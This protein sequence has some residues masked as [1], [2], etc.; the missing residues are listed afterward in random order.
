VLAER[1]QHGRR[2]G[3]ALDGVGAAE[4]LVQHEQAA[5]LA[6][7]IEKATDRVDLGEV[8]APSPG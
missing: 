7:R 1:T 6:V 3:D 2:D 5:G 4:R 8:V